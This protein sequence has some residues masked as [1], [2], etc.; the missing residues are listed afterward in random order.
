MSERE[1]TDKAPMEAPLSGLERSLIDEFLGMRGHDH[2]SLERLTAAERDELLKE[3]SVYASS[4]L[5]EI[6][7]RA[8]YVHSMHEA[9]EDRDK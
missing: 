4:K 9:Q 3:A 7:S 1:R 8:K 2:A 6:E 5:A